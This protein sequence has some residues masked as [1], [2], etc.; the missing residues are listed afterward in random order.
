MKPKLLVLELWGL[1]DLVIASRFLQAASDHFEVTLLAKPFGRELQPRLW[2][3]VHIV[4]LVAPWTAFRAKYRLAHWPWRQLCS[5]TRQLRQ[6]AF[7]YGVS[8]RWDPRDHLWL[9][10]IG[11]KERI[12]FP[13][14]GSHRWLTRPLARPEPEAH[15]YEYWRSLAQALGLKLPKRPEMPQRKA[16]PTP[17][18][19]VHSGAGQSVR[20]W[21]LDRFYQVVVRLRNRGWH[22]QVAC[23]PPQ[24]DWWHQAGE[25][26]AVAP[27]T[28]AQLFELIDRATLF[29]GNDSGP[30]HL[31][32]I[33]GVPTFT[34]FGPQLPEWFAPLHPAARWIE[35]K[36]CPFKPCFD[37]CRW[38]EPVCLTTISVD[39]VWRG[40][41]PW[42][43]QVGSAT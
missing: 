16:P 34:L 26:T 15:R 14:L 28:V 3:G 30:G 10:L 12:G 39:Q 41:E 38:P 42:L 2:P 40:L 27:R 8:A 32:A 21:P 37:Y 23:D 36:P 4:P 31:A 9:R 19:L 1:G 29:I 7:D 33:C 13:R 18:I 20:V 5:V 24:A 11:A 43:A 25:T 17:C 22:V 6:Q 35:G